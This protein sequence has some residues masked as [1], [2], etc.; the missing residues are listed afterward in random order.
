[1]TPTEKT[2]YNTKPTH[3]VKILSSDYNHLTVSM[4]IVNII[5]SKRPAVP[6]DN[7]L[8]YN[9]LCEDGVYRY[10]SLMYKEIE[11]IGTYVDKI[12]S[13]VESG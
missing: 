5:G 1:M 7:G 9:V 13:E 11:V 3:W 4:P 10:M 6:S 12:E 8:G 2:P